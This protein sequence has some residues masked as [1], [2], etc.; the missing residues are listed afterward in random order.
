MIRKTEKR[1]MEAVYRLMCELERTELDKTS[2]T[3]I[4]EQQLC[5]EQWESYVFEQD[6]AVIG[7]INM[8]FE[9]QLH[10][11]DTVAEILELCVTANYRNLGIGTQLFQKAKEAARQ[12]HAVRLEL[13][14]STW[15]TDA[16]RFYERQG[17]E[18]SHYNLT[19]D[20]E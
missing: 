18:K 6:N 1:D 3:E 14:T 13:S 20:Y 8:R 10:H 7:F 15:R 16:Q 2:F 17:M 5:S 4:F 12:R 19:Y 11:A 9:R